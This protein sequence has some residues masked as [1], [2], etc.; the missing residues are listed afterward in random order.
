MFCRPVAEQ[1]K[2]EP[3]EENKEG[4]QPKEVKN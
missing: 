2:E 1:P 4:E 3:K